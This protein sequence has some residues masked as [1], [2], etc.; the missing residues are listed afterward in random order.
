MFPINTDIILYFY[1]ILYIMVAED[2]Y[3]CAKS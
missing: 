1:N 3:Y 2:I